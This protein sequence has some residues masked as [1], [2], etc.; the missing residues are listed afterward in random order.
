MKKILILYAKYGGGH[1]SAAHSIQTYLDENYL[2]VEVKTVDCMEYVSPFLNA[3]STGAYKQ[4]TRK[5]PWAWKKLYYNSTKGTLSKISISVNRKMTEKL[6]NLFR[7]FLPDIVISTQ[8]FASQMINYIKKS[9]N[10]DCKIVTIFTDFKTHEQWLI[11]K[12][13]CDLFFVS[14][15]SMKEQLIQQNVPKEKVF[16][17]GVPLSDR[18][19]EDF[20][21]EDI[22]RQFSLDINK[23]VI[24]FFGG[25]EFGL[26][27]ERTVQILRSF[28]KHLDKYQ[29]IAISGKN[30]KMNNEF[31]KLSNEIN[32]NDLHIL[33]YTQYVPELMYVSSLV[34]TKP[35]GL[36]SSESLASGLPMLIIN[37]IPG[38]ED[39]NAEFL[40]N[41]GVGVWLK[42][43]DN[44]DDVVGD[45]LL[46]P[47]KLKTMKQNCLTLAKKDS[48]ENICKIILGK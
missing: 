12:E 40:E 29:I 37:P 1:L 14:N 5:A 35:G 18:F 41:A 45:I 6:Y 47:E 2:D 15:D 17:T 48:T 16:V 25:G 9:K 22:F 46:N 3:L 26:G 10:V 19:L 38:Q 33:K 30:K 23:K 44:I 13:Y 24:L 7:E 4:M 27:K 20:N 32:N 11:G 36:T 28:V 8:P 42:N 34:V 21:K 31:I 39:E 43:D